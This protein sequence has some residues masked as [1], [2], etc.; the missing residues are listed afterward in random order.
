MLEFPLLISVLRGK[1]NRYSASPRKKEIKNKN[2][3]IFK[4][5]MCMY[6]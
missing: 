3:F 4:A 2:M 1:W 5:H 6:F